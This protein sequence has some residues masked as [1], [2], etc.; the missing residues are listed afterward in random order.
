MVA[1][2]PAWPFNGQKRALV[3]SHLGTASGRKARGDSPRPEEAM[4]GLKQGGE[5]GWHALE[6]R[7]HGQQ[8]AGRQWGPWL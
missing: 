4:C 2:I 6:M 7:W 1:S 5:Q 8:K 3:L